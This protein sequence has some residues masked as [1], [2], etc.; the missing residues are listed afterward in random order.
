MAECDLE[1]L[2]ED[3]CENGFSCLD[4]KAQQAVRLQLLCNWVAGGG[5]GGG[6]T[7]GGPLNAV[8]FNSPLGTFAGSADL[9]FDDATDVLALAGRQTIANGTANTT[10]LALTGYSLTGANA[11][12]MVSLAGT[13]NTT[14]VPTAIDLNITNTASAA[15]S[16]LMD[17]RTGGT[18]RFSVR[19]DGRITAPSA[20]I[21]TI[22]SPGILTLSATTD[23]SFESTGSA[24]WSMGGPILR[25]AAMTIGLSP[26]AA[27][28]MEFNDGVT[29]GTFR[30]VWVRHLR[31]ATAFTVA[32]LPAAGVQGRMAYVTDALTPTFLTLAVGGGAVI[33]PVFDNGTAWVTV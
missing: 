9:T 31:L 3:A 29:P 5:G 30:D 26:N 8:Q 12:S 11:Q 16:L 7:P 19:V 24:R 20:I 22:I 6:G 4:P 21:T 25:N 27:G 14:G 23:I 17:L 10:S 2:Q 32:T 28:I 18:S 1:T 15:T 13:W 33:A